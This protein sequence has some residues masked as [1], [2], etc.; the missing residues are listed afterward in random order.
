MMGSRLEML[1]EKRSA[2][3][4]IQR[5][6]ESGPDRERVW[7]K[8]EVRVKRVWGVWMSSKMAGKSAKNV[9]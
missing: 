3:R 9:S 8:V 1:P 2:G 7:M 4:W 5:D 6:E